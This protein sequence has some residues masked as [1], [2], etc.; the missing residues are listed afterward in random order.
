MN[1]L[2]VAVIGTGHL[3]RIHARLINEID[4]VTLV[5]IS[6]PSA[7]ARE[8]VAQE[9]STE[10]FADHRELLGKID[11]AVIAAPT[12][13]HHP[14]TKELIDNGIHCLV[15]KPVT[16]TVQEAN[17][18]IAAAKKANVV[19]QVGH[20]ER[21]N[22]AVAAI[23]P[24]VESPK[25]IEATRASGY[26]FRSTDV[27]VVQDLMIHDLDIVLSLV[28][29][30]LIE[31]QA[32]G[33]TVFGPHVD[34]AAARLVF[35]CG[36]VA[37]LSASRTSHEPQ[38]AMHIYSRRG[39]AGID[40]AT[41]TATVV[42]PSAPI[43][44]KELDPNTLSDEQK[45]NI[46]DHLFSDYLPVQE[47]LPG[48]ANPLLDEQRDF[49]HCIQTGETPRVTGEDGRDAVSA[50]EKILA[51]IAEHQWDGKTQTPSIPS[52]HWNAAAKAEAQELQKLQRKAG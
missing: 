15:E 49:I 22:P 18:L 21:F 27:S 11:A 32:L 19:F 30:P 20:V 26:T 23:G 31:V 36:C 46:Q 8:R 45:K 14:I 42:R 3:G 7:E 40:F 33:V 2:R 29:S 28:R 4:D 37:N 39:Y 10:P 41:R 38:R 48:E 47:I 52:P 25:Y 16:T 44:R 12:R 1:T 51:S 24:H 17:E 13:L 6:D 35:D 34:M 5:G 9:C 43:V 50:A